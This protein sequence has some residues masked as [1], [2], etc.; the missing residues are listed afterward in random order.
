MTERRIWDAPGHGFGDIWVALSYCAH[1][2]ALSGEPE[3]L[4]RWIN[5]VA[6]RDRSALLFEMLEAFDFPSGCSAG[7]EARPSNTSMHMDS[8]GHRYAPTKERWVGDGEYVAY[9]FDGRSSANFKN[10]PSADLALF[11]EWAHARQLPLMYVGLPANVAQCVDM[12]KH[13]RYFV[14]ACSGMSSLALSVGCPTFVIEYAIKIDWWY[15]PNLVRKC[16]GMRDF[17]TKASNL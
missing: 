5:P 17:F 8:W 9:Q 15:G 13:A 16:V 14:G 6:Q 3:Y 10:P 1:Q 7:V 12:L 11:D 4:S 2:S